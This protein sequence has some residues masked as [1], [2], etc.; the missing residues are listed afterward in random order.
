MVETVKPKL[1]YDDSLDAFGIHG[2]GGFVGNLLVGI[3]ASPMFGGNQLG[4]VIASQCAVQMFAGCLVALY[5]VV[6]TWVILKVVSAA[7]GGLRVSEVIE[8]YGCDQ[9][10][11]EITAYNA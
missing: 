4:L 11:K 8:A 6:G 5:S 10:I 1:G 3:F 2:A 7:C 9:E